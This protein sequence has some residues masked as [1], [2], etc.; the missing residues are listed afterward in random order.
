MPPLQP[1]L[2]FAGHTDPRTILTCTYT[3]DQ[4]NKSPAYGLDRQ[5]LRLT[6]HNWLAYITAVIYLSVDAGS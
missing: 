6:L 1:E 3:R 5:L 4:L 2:A